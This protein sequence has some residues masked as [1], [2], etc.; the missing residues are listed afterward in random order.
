MQAFS[1]C[2]AI[3]CDLVA[4]QIYCSDNVML[5]KPYGRVPSTDRTGQC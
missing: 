5:Q 3:L 4:T 1:N 2:V